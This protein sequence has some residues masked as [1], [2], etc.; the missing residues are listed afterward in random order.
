MT[1]FLLTVKNEQ[2]YPKH[3]VLLLNVGFVDGGK[4]IFRT[5]K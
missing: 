1:V 3:S 4:P 2:K 5:W